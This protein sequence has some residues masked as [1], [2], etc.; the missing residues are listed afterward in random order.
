VQN[1][2]GQRRD[3]RT[4]QVNVTNSAGVSREKYDSCVQSNVYT[5]TGQNQ[6]ET[7]NEKILWG[8]NTD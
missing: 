8:V 3:S 2:L 1:V 6:S 4:H 5:N 7:P